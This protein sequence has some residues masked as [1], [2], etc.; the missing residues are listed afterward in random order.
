MAQ[1]MPLVEGDGEI[2]VGALRLGE[3][4]RRRLPPVVTIKSPSWDARW[5][6]EKGEVP[7]F[8]IGDTVKL[9]ASAVNSDGSMVPDEDISWEIHID[10]WWKTPAVTLRGG[11]TSYILPDV[12]NEEDRIKSKD[13]ILLGVIT[14]KVKGKNGTQAVEPFAML[15]GK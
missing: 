5:M 2:V 15:I 1:Q 12:T 7:K 9:S 10:P 3:E 11:N 8:K 4:R 6:D 14:V 13:R